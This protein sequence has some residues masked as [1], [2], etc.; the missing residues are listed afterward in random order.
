VHSALYCLGNVGAAT[1][2]GQLL[3]STQGA[4][5]S[6][7]LLQGLHLL[8]EKKHRIGTWAI[9]N[10]FKTKLSVTRHQAQAKKNHNEI[11]PHP[12]TM[13]ILKPTNI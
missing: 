4:F 8:S 3:F 7:A 12:I 10:K 13:G 1:D 11:P 2:E 6:A 9:K 5:Q